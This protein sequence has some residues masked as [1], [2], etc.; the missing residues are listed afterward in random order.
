LG[1]PSPVLARLQR[2]LTFAAVG[3]DRQADHEARDFLILDQ[4][5]EKRRVLVAAAARVGHE[6]GGNLAIR[7]AHRQA[8]ADGA[9]IDAQKPAHRYDSRP[10]FFICSTSAL[11]VPSSRRSA[12]SVASPSWMMSRLLTPMVV[13]SLPGSPT[14]TQPVVLMPLCEAST[15]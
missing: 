14:M 4:L 2:F 6:R 10:F 3:V 12:T 5:L 13:I 7:V 15:V 1:E 8:D 11:T 9:V